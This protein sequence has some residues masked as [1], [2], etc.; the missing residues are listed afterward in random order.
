MIV[1]KLEDI[2]HTDLDVVGE[3]WNS[4]RLLLQKDGMGF[5][6]TVTVIKKG[7][8]NYHW[9]KNHFEACYC[10]KG[11]GEIEIADENG[12][13]TGVIYKISPGTMYALNEHD[14]HYIRATTA[15][16]HLVCVFNPPLTGTEIHDEEGTYPV[17]TEE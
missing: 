15:D 5:S 11:E 10:I 2:I 6:M 16:L 12:K 9:Y 4:R 13:K 7:A 8:D 3:N 17:L 14:R 1:R